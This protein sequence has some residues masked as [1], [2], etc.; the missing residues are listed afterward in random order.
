MKF[1][2]SKEYFLF[3]MFCIMPM[4]GSVASSNLWFA[5]ALW[6]MQVPWA[7][8]KVKENWNE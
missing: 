1:F 7:I 2:D 6:V 3:V 4:L 5:A 8:M